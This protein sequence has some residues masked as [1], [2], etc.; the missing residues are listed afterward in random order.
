MQ[1]SAVLVKSGRIELEASHDFLIEESSYGRV[2][3]RHDVKAPSPLPAPSP[4]VMAGP[5]LQP[6]A[7]ALPRQ[8]ARPIA[9]KG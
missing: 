8:R 4:S 9:N 1:P 2:M 6:C 3:E 7:G 5:T